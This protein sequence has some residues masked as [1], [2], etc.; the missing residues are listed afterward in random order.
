M[1]TYKIPELKKITKDQGYRHVR[2]TDSDGNELVKFNPSTISVTERIEEMETRLKSPAIKDGY[3][4]FEGKMYNG[5]SQ[6]PDK[7]YILKGTAKDEIKPVEEAPI[8]EKDHPLTYDQAIKMNKEIATLKAEKEYLERDRDEWKVKY[9]SLMDEVEEIMEEAPDEEQLGEGGFELSDNMQKFLGT[10]SENLLPVLDRHYDLKEKKLQI[11]EGKV[12][13]DLAK[14]GIHIGP[15]ETNTNGESE[16]PEHEVAPGE[17]E[18]LN[19]EDFNKWV[20][21]SMMDLAEKDP[22]RYKEVVGAANSGGDI[23]DLLNGGTGF[24][25]DPEDPGQVEEGEPDE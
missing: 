5:K 23:E 21:E 2:L 3:Y 19:D 17:E 1:K 7:Y 10:L 4:C 12:I 6:R 8:P 11:E 20:T 22:E 18:E 16:L 9:N 15:A 25:A 14:A 24:D 13:R